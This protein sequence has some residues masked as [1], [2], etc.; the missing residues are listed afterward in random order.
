MKDRNID[1][2]GVD[3]YLFSNVHL[4][5]SPSVGTFRAFIIS[6]NKVYILIIASLILAQFIIF[7]LMYPFPDFFSDSYSYLFAAYRHLNAN[8]WPIGYSKFLALFHSLTHSSIALNFFQ[9]F[10]LELSSLY[11]YLT[12]IYFYHTGRNTRIVLNLF[13][14]FNPL[15]LYLSNYVS[16]DAIFIAISILWFTQLL[17][18]IHR[19]NAFHLISQGI[20]IFIAFTFRYNAFYYPIISA[21]ALILSRQRVWVKLAGMA[22]PI[23]LIIPFVMFSSQ[24]TLKLVG[25][26]QFPPILGGWQ[27]GN[28]A[29][30]MREF[31]NVDSNKLPSNECR[32]LDRLARNFFRTVPQSDR[33]LP[34]YVANFFIRQP[35][36]PLKRYMLNHYKI[37]GDMS[38]VIA[39]GKVS[40][41]FKDYGLYLIRNYPFAFARHYLLINTKNYFL[42]P[43]E[44]LEIYNL[45][46]DE[47][48]P[49]AAYWF[50][51]PNLEIRSISKGLQGVLLFL[52]PTLFLLFNAYYAYNLVLFAA[53]R[54]FRQASKSFM[55]AQVIM[56]SFMMLNFSFSVFANIIV[57]RYQVFPMI[58]CLAFSSL[59]ADFLEKIHETDAKS[60]GR[61]TIQTPIDNAALHLRNM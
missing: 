57:I 56:F 49:L 18:I 58:I 40:P 29:L 4:K 13:L 61:I 48:L 12:I 22:L 23:I 19:P 15:A 28:N 46:M 39:W 44:K 45:G 34:A 41:V 14:F 51:Y 21:I 32:E 8:I 3:K 60:E 2:L 43:L 42:P 6:E 16:S 30:Y 11:F 25:S 24:A 33:D 47:L 59:L 31:V 26:R 53:R 52:Y 20:L 27:W 17:W 36:A 50:D 1:R 35:E 5:Q 55:S 7:K 38:E 10:V 9:Y 37:E 54:K